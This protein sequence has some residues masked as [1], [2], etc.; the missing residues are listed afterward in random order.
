MG[1]RQEYD[2][3]GVCC[4]VWMV[5]NYWVVYPHRVFGAPI[6]KMLVDRYGI[7]R[8]GRVVCLPRGGTCEG[9]DAQLYALSTDGKHTEYPKSFCIMLMRN[10][11][12]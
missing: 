6:L 10:M 2:G 7:D 12:G 5:M 11:L 1:W 8:A 9:G 3:L 4:D